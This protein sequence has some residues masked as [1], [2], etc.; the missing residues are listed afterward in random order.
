L[1]SLFLPPFKSRK[2]VEIAE[3]ASS[4]QRCVQKTAAVANGHSW[5]ILFWVL[6]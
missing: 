3:V 1:L 4:T 2:A 5:R 6:V